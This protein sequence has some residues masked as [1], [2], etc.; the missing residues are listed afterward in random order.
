MVLAGYGGASLLFF[1]ISPF[2]LG[3]WGAGRG[4]GSSTR[5]S[6]ST[7]ESTSASSTSGVDTGLGS[8][9]G[10]G[11]EP[12]SLAGEKKREEANLA[13]AVDAAE[14]EAAGMADDEDIGVRRP[15]AGENLSWWDILLGK[16]DREIFEHSMLHDDTPAMGKSKGKERERERE[17]EKEK[18]KNKLKIKGSAVHVR[19]LPR[20][21]IS[22]VTDGVW[23]GVWER[24]FDAP[25]L[26]PD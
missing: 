3:S 8:G 22:S 9:L 10:L 20:S 18:E 26:G 21:P 16:H 11:D 13:S 15:V 7:S 4:D 1:G 12:F 23:V 5:G 2:A 6:A 17:K 25:I 14:A 24:A 19:S